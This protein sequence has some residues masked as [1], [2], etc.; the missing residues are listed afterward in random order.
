VRKGNFKKKNVKKGK[1]RLGKGMKQVNGR[2]EVRKCM[3]R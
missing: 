2:R 1:M 3:G